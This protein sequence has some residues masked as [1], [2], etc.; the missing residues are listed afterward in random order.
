MALEIGPISFNKEV[1][2]LLEGENLPTADLRTAAR[3]SNRNDQTSRNPV[4]LFG[5]RCDDELKGLVGLEYYGHVALLRSLVVHQNFRH[6]GSGRLLV[7]FAERQAALSGVRTLY[8]LTTT[9]A[10]YFARIGY[11]ALSR[12]DAPAAIATTAQFSDLCPSSASFMAKTLFS[13]DESVPADV[14]V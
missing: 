7:D 2:A 12:D 9:A 5:A 11:Q 6:S 10:D 13:S 14:E 3:L 8:L 4:E 1:G